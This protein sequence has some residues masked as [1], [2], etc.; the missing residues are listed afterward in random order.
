MIWVVVVGFFAGI[1]SGMGIGG[2]TILIPALIFMLDLNQHQVQ[3]INLLYFIPTAI[4]ALVIH[5]KNKNVLW[6]K[7]KPI[8]I[9]GLLGAIGGAFLA[10]SLD[11]T[12]LKK[13]FGGFL[14]LMGL[15]EIFTKKEEDNYGKK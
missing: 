3:G 6:T 10:I 11:P 15:R 8:A 9:Y 2:G 14:F 4:I 5:N 13:L 12:L 1:I 7:T